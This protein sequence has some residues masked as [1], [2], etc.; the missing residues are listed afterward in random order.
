M[1][2]GE[3]LWSA[4]IDGVDVDPVYDPHLQLM[5]DHVVVWVNDGCRAEFI[6]D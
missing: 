5:G 6:V 3:P 2:T 4:E 1:T